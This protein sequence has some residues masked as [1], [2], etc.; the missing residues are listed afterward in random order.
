LL[1]LQDDWVSWGGHRT[2]EF[3]GLMKVA[4]GG[5][6]VSLTKVQGGHIEMKIPKPGVL[7]FHSFF[8]TFQGLVG[9]SAGFQDP[10]LLPQIL[11]QEL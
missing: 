10:P 9:D 2:D 4:L 7:G 5:I 11:G 1:N 6:V 8:G 3:Q